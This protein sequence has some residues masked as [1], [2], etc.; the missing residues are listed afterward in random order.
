MHGRGGRRSSR[1]RGDVGLVV[2]GG[3]GFLGCLAHGVFL[4]FG[5]G[6]DRKV[7]PK[8][9]Q[10]W[11]ERL[12]SSSSLRDHHEAVSLGNVSGDERGDGSGFR[13]GELIEDVDKG[14]APSRVISSTQV[15]KR[16]SK[17]W[18]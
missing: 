3:L 4:L 11:R 2:L 5:F 13:D 1:L 7:E 9:F 10:A 16:Y 14:A 15:E 17:S 6:V 18:L 8:S 12:S